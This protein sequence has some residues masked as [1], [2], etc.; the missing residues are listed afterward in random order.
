MGT[1]IFGALLLAV[2]FSNAECSSED[3]CG[4]GRLVK[5]AFTFLDVFGENADHFRGPPDRRLVKRSIPG[6]G[7]DDPNG[8]LVK[9][10]IPGYGED[11]PN[12]RLVK[13]S[14]PGYGEDDPNGRL[15]KRS[16]PGHGED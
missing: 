16:I 3:G 11:D 6:H 4:N 12:G 13:R 8:R 9:R 14:I 5:R 1:I 2:P 10:S 7:E 15:V